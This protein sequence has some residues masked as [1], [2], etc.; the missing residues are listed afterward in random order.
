MC[1][2]WEGAWAVAPQSGARIATRRPGG[3]EGEK[4]WPGGAS[5]QA[6]RPLSGHRGPLARL[7]R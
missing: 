6:L 7:P 2:G 1:E 3:Y 5:A 4:A